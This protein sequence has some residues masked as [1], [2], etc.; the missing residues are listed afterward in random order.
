MQIPGHKGRYAHNDETLF[1]AD[2]LTD[3]IRD[4]VALQGF[5]DD[6]HFTNGWLVRA[7]QLYASRIGADHTRFLVGG[8]T[9][10]NIA[11]LLTS[12][13]PERAVAV[14][15]TSHRSALGGLV[16][17]GAVPSWIFPTIH[18]EYGIPVG[19][20]A[21]AITDLPGEPTA[22]F[23]TAPAY[24]GTISDVRALA[25]AAHQRGLPLVVDQA[26]GAHLDWREGEGALHNGADLVITSIHKALTG[27]S[28]TAIISCR[29]SKIDVARLDRSVDITATTSPSATLL[30]SIDATRF[31]LEDDGGAA[32]DRAITLTDA[33]RA[34]LRQIR[35]LVVLDDTTLG[36]HTDPLKIALF[37]PGTGTTGTSVA[38]ALWKVRIGIESADTDTLV[39]SVGL[40][41][42]EASLTT[43]VEFIAATV[44]Q[45]RAEPRGHVPSATWQVRP[46]VVMTPRQAMFAPRRRI[47]LIEAAG[48]ISA[49]Q[50]CP[51]PPGVPLVAPGERVTEELIEAIRLA[52]ANGRVAYCSDAT[53]STIEIV[54]Q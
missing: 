35:G 40:L 5:A 32:I 9:Q 42:D 45:E 7:E 54:D 21:S 34:R 50:F 18:P 37:F 30:A 36:S 47:A 26:W 4:D 52:G 24:V 51:Y 23:I 20:P 48:E 16:L 17:S 13:Q 28:Q 2:V 38:Q 6:N 31:A 11:A 22:V 12:S 3:L 27:Y 8:G 33:A 25:D 43:L 29:T 53:L 44:E 14:D 39:A 10:G 19:V 41:D 15:R 49:E 46:D 1:G